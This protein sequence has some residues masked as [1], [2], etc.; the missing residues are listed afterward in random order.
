MSN[1]KTV[2]SV[3]VQGDIYHANFWKV[4]ELSNK[5]QFDLCKL[6]EAACEAL[7]NLG[8]EIKTKDTKPEKGAF[9]TLKSANFPFTV[10]DTDG[11]GVDPET[12]V[13]NG[14]RAKMRISAY[15]WKFKN[16]T[17]ISPQTNRVIIT[18]LIE[19]NP[20]GGD[21]DEEAV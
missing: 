8:I 4:N 15:N 7:S 9:I 5:Y 14:T 16:K 12:R 21:L 17:G 11:V 2:E 3:M 6:S 10:V 1:A 13:G 20:E 18:S 19:Y